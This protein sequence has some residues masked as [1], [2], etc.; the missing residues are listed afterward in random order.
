MADVAVLEL[1]V[2]VAVLVVVV[3]QLVLLL[4]LQEPLEE[5]GLGIEQC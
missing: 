4:L 1:L 3:V 5:G 2:D